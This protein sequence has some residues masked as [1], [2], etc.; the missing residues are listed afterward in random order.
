MLF[1]GLEDAD[2]TMTTG[3]NIISLPRLDYSE[4]KT[5][6]ERFVENVHVLKFSCCK[7][8]D[9]NILT[10]ELTGLLTSSKFIKISTRALD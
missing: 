6:L 3:T 4:K 1:D 10:R 2:R 8:F 9:F 7:E 5:F